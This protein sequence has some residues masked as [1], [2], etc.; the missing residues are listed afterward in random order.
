MRLK[1]IPTERLSK[2]QS[3]RSDMPLQ[4]AGC[5]AQKHRSKPAEVK[6]RSHLRILTLS[7]MV[8]LLRTRLA[9]PRG[10]WST[11][12]FSRWANKVNTWD[13]AAI[14][15]ADDELRVKRHLQAAS[16]C[17]PSLTH[18]FRL[19][20][21]DF[22]AMSRRSSSTPIRDA[23]CPDPSAS[24]STIASG[25]GDGRSQSVSRS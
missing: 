11:G 9:L 24:D 8:P 17:E 12:H 18:L 2:R 7:A 6:A 16:N 20:K 13:P 15:A 25:H 3:P 14:A 10:G 1:S 4:P 22:H 19:S 23:L 5:N 21:A